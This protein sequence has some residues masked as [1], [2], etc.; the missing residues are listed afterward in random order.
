M[1]KGEKT[2]RMPMKNQEL[3]HDEMSG[4]IIEVTKEMIASEG[5]HNVN[6]RKIINKM[7]VTN[8]V[9]YNRFHNADEVLRT[10]YENAVIKM[11][12]SFKSEYDSEE[13]FFEYCMDMAVKVLENTYDIKMKFSQYMFEHD[14]L[15]ETNRIWWTNEINKAFKYAREHGI[16]KDIDPELLSYSV[17][18]IC[19]GYSSDAVNRKLSRE[20]A[21]KYFKFGFGYF[22]EGI[23]Q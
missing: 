1:L 20:D 16:I 17:W 19:R 12:S 13:E 5:A 7:G 15:T 4:K 8:R 9:F 23:K 18:C 21:V 10:V 22:L 14:A 6:V 11:R 3:I 2:G